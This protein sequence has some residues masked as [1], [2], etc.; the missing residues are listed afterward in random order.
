MSAS[1]MDTSD[2]ELSLQKSIEDEISRF[3][4]KVRQTWAQKC[5]SLQDQL[6]RAQREIAEVKAK[7]AERERKY[8]EL[9]ERS[10]NY[11]NTVKEWYE[12]TTT[13]V[14]HPS[15]R[16]LS[17]SDVRGPHSDSNA[18]CTANSSSNATSAASLT[19]NKKRRLSSSSSIGSKNL[20]KLAAERAAARNVSHTSIC[21]TE[22]VSSSSVS[23][24]RLPMS[25]PAQLTVPVPVNAAKIDYNSSSSSS[26][27]HP[28][29]NLQDIDRAGTP[30]VSNLGRDKVSATLDPTAKMNVQENGKHSDENYHSNTNEKNQSDDENTTST[31]EPNYKYHEVVR[32]KKERRALQGHDCPS[33]RSFLDAV[34]KDWDGKDNGMFNRSE[35]VQ[36]CSRHRSKHEPN[37][38]PPGFWELSFADSVAARGEDEVIGS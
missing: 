5:G 18:P 17:G 7:L 11:R 4:A 32:K 22:T 12:A 9:K 37:Q 23:S 25:M 20:E 27:S 28:L 1:E 8:T 6:D 13:A 16:H 14:S 21:P 2:M 30:P 10:L 35:L 34:C 38:T 15:N 31:N 24:S 36:E 29:N 33:C 19:K 26:T 3:S